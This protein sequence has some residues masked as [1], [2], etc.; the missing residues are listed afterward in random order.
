MRNLEILLICLAV[1]GFV[2]AI[3]SAFAGRIMGISA[4]GFSQGCTNLLLIAIAVAVCIKGK[5]K[6]SGE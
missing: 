5:D 3:I 2:L 1:I 4:E 6:A